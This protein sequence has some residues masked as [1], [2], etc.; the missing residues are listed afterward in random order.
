M[1]Q[2]SRQVGSEHSISF[3]PK[4]ALN[5]IYTS[6]YQSAHLIAVLM[7]RARLRANEKE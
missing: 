4:E 2:N 6:I 7:E 5:Q 3:T 1:T